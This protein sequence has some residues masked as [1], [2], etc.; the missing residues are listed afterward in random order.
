MPARFK[1]TNSVNAWSDKYHYR[2]ELY[3]VWW[4]QRLFDDKL[5][6]KVGKINAA[7]EFDQVLSPPT[8]P[9][10]PNRAAWTVSDLLYAPVGEN[11]TLFGRLPSWA[12]SAWGATVRSLAHE[13]RLRGIWLF[14]WQ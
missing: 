9:E 12:D 2:L 8:I 6:I 5:I 3:E 7:A 11:P 14:R 4:R 13:R 10:Q 1:F